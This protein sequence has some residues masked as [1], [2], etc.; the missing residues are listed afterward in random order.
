MV[1]WQRMAIPRRL[2]PASV[3]SWWSA[4]LARKSERGD[5]SRGLGGWVYPFTF[6]MEFAQTTRLMASN[7]P[8]PEAKERRDSSL[9]R[10]TAS[11]PNWSRQVETKKADTL[12]RIG[13]GSIPD[14]P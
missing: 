5:C 2:V 14:Y 13:V 3:S 7:T 11:I 10:L 8:C 4:F 6:R 12:A 9:S 1:M